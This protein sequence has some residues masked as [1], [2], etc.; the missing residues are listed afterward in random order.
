[1]I[2]LSMN[3][4]SL[5]QEIVENAAC[6]H[7]VTIKAAAGLRFFAARLISVGAIILLVVL[8]LF[9]SRVIFRE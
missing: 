2:T 5:A 1:M 8:D 4:A 6:Y 9:S 7:L 3:E